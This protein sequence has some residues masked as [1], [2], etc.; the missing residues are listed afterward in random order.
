MNKK[1]YR[2]GFNRQMFR[3]VLLHTLLE[4]LLPCFYKYIV[5]AAIKI[6]QFILI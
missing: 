3:T 6:K 1:G 4:I 2:R 5:T